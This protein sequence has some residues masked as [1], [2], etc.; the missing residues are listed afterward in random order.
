MRKNINIS[1]DNI[2][3]YLLIIIPIGVMANMVFALLTTDSSRFECIGSF[4]LN[5]LFWAALLSL[6]PLVISSLRLGIWTRFLGKPM[7]F[8]ELLRISMA[9]ELGSAVTPTSGGGGYVKLG[10]LVQKGFTVGQAT[11][12]MTMSSME[13][14]TFYLIVIPVTVFLTAAS[15]L[16]MFDTIVKEVKKS[17]AAFRYTHILAALR[18]RYFI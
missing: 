7:P 5:Y 1:F 12:L 14:I 3:R 10:M 9:Y 2:F 8:T 15:Q 17:S 18:D 6:A 13:H 11:S 4:K 16:P